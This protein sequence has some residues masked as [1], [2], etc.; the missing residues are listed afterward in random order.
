MSLANSGTV[1]SV[2]HLHMRVSVFTDQLSFITS[3]EKV[4]TFTSSVVEQR[5]Y[6]GARRLC[7]TL[8]VSNTK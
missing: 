7:V 4:A 1:C 5:R 3:A 8:C 2:Y 6:G